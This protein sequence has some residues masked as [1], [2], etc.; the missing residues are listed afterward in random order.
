MSNAALKQPIPQYFYT[1]TGDAVPGDNKADKA[2]TV[3][4]ESRFPINQR[5][6]IGVQAQG[7]GDQVQGDI[8]PVYD[9][10]N[11]GTIPAPFAVGRS[12]PSASNA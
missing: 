1:V 7:W 11:P 2:F 8:S 5:G 6:E 10:N 12:T 9:S 3:Y 4:Q